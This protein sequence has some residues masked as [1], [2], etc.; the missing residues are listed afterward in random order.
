M[1]RF[2]AGV[3]VMGLAVV[4]IALVSAPT[5]VGGRSQAWDTVALAVDPQGATA[6]QRDAQS[7]ALELAR[8]DAQRAA[9]VAQERTIRLAAVVTGVIVLAF[10]TVGGLLITHRPQ[11]VTV[12]HRLEVVGDGGRFEVVDDSE[13]VTRALARLEVR[14]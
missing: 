1:S 8:I 7:Y 10:A 2:V 5:A 9:T 4:A 6:M 14:Q 12:V 13:A 11:R 3:V